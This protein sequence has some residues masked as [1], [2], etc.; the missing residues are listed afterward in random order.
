MRPGGLDGAAGGGGKLFVLPEKSEEE[1][2]I[3]ISPLIGAVTDWLTAR[4]LMVLLILVTI[5]TST[6]L[7]K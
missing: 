3:A 7:M 4:S 6:L 5:C 1:D 2:R